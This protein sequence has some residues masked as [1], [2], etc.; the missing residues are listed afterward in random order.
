MWGLPTIGSLPEPYLEARW[1]LLTIP[2]RGEFGLAEYAPLAP[3]L[4]EDRRLARPGGEQDLCRLVKAKDLTTNERPKDWLCH[5][6]QIGHPP[7]VAAFANTPVDH[8]GLLRRVGDG[9]RRTA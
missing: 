4:G 6:F 8:L 7:A 3:R 1:R 9:V 2:E 5:A